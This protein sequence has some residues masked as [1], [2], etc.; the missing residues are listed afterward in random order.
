MD[1]SDFRILR[2]L[3]DGSYSDVV[4]A[5]LDDDFPSLRNVESRAPHLFALKIVDK[6]HAVKNHVVNQMYLERRL[7]EELN[8]EVCVA[9]LFFSFKD[10]ANLYFGLEPCLYGE[11]YDAIEEGLERD[12][13]VFFAAE[14]VVMLGVLRRHGIVHRDLKP[15]NLLLGRNGH[16]KLIDFGSALWLS[17]DK[18]ASAWHNEKT[19]AM[20]VGTA[21]YVAPEVLEHT[22]GSAVSYGVDL[23]AFGVIL[24][25]MATGVT[26]F[27]G[28][29][30]YLVFQNVLKNE[31][32]ML[33]K[34]LGED[35]DARDLISRL[36]ESDPGKRIGFASVD[37][38]RNHKF[39][40][41]VDWDAL[42]DELRP[43][44]Y[45]LRQNLGRLDAAEESDEEDDDWELQGLRSLALTMK[46]H[47]LSD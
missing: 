7:H 19:K 22:D 35:E 14:I 28:A 39:F 2:R 40:S 6:Q 47:S 9:R 38:V 42:Y 27:R 43:T 12:E 25:Q 34:P 5:C 10:E 33:C 36:L 31:P 1:V 30:E 32:D 8:E 18:E 17:D 44:K 4:L 41:D 13:V 29:S 16:L 24:Y 20:L 45:F 23:W 11:L 15:E 26:P 3:G 46:N 37:D 21:E